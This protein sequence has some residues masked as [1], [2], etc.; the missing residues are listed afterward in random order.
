MDNRRGRGRGQINEVLMSLRAA[1]SHKRR[2]LVVVVAFYADRELRE[3]LAHLSAGPDVV[4]IDNDPLSSATASIA[5][6]SGAHYFA[7]PANV[8]FATAVNYAL[9]H[10]WDG[11][12]DVLL[13]NPDARLTLGTLGHLHDV[14]HSDPK[15]AAVSPRLVDVSGSLQRTV[16]PIPSPIAVWADAFALSALRAK[17]P[18]FLVGAV[19]MLKASAIDSVGLFDEKY[20]LYSEEADWQRR[21]RRAGWEL[22]LVDALQATHRG[23]ASSSEIGKRLVLF[24][25][26]SEIFGRKWYGRVGWQVMRIGAILAAARRCLTGS[27]RSREL[28]RQTLQLFLAGPLKTARRKGHLA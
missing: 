19:L 27:S 6:E 10:A 7:M 5:T 17:C 25:A 26:S 2:P 1:E 22:L 21:A 16:W 13:L 3:C 9:F 24:H 12:R 20:F 4:V 28:A 8:G 23:A 15:L 18:S 14:L 11:R